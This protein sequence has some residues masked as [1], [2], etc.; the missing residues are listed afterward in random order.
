VDAVARVLFE[1]VTPQQ[2]IHVLL[3]R[4]SRDEAIS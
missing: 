2:A 4:E 1:Q 3:S